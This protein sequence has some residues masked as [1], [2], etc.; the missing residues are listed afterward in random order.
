[1][2]RIICENQNSLISKR[3]I[4]VN[5]MIAYEIFNYLHRPTKGNQGNVGIK[6]DMEKAFDIFEWSFIQK[7]LIHIGFP[8]Q[9]TKIIMK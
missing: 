4:N 6:I 8:N 3:L 7:T 5:T 1:M 9:I 2:P